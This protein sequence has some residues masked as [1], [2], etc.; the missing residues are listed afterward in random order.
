[1]DMPTPASSQ[2]ARELTLATVGY[3]PRRACR[4]SASGKQ[5]Q[6]A[7]ALAKL[8]SACVE[9]I[10]GSASLKHLGPGRQGGLYRHGSVFP[11]RVF[12]YDQGRGEGQLREGERRIQAEIRP[13][14]PL[15]KALA[16]AV[17]VPR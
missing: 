4:D 16:V 5:A 2:L 15:R 11:R 12:R 8:S 10:G 3:W 6:K 14:V 9:M 1:L 17:K 7:D 13:A